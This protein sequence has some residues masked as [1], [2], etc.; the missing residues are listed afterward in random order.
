MELSK[1]YPRAFSQIAITIADIQAVVK[2][3]TSGQ[4]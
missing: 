3:K 2:F 1:T 4:D